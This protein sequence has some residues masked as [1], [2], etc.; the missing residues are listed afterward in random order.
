MGNPERQATQS[1]D[2]GA[3]SGLRFVTIERAG[4]LDIRVDH[5]AGADFRAE[6][7]LRRERGDNRPIADTDA[8]G[9]VRSVRPHDV[10][11]VRDHR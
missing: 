2:D 8:D 4:G 9:V 10:I 3:I 7:E 5:E 6:L 1:L 11:E